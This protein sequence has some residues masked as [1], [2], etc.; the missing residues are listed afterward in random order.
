[1]TDWDGTERREVEM[2]TTRLR[3]KRPTFEAPVV[4]LLV[5]F[6]AML[7]F[8]AASLWG[9]G[10]IDQHQDAEAKRADQF[11]TQL[12]CFV[13]RFTQGRQGTDV[14]TD[15]GFLTVGGK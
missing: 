4:G 12:T 8:Q 1:M 3:P 11:R 2:L 7:L 5:G 6:A 14:L 10:I 15:C 9:H 13:V